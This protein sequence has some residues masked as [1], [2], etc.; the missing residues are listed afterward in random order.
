MRLSSFSRD[1]SYVQDHFA[2]PHDMS[3]GRVAVMMTVA[4][5]SRGLDVAS[6]S[7]YPQEREVVAIGQYRVDAI[8][9]YN[10]NLSNYYMRVPTGV[11]GLHLTQ[12]G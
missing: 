2:S 5:G 6:L 3:G 9:G 4:E 11:V 12:I 1:S 10:P 8:D 7:A